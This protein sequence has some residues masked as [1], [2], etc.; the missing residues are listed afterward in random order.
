MLGNMAKSEL[1]FV[2]WLYVTVIIR[3]GTSGNSNTEEAY[4]FY[5]KSL[6]VMQ[7]TIQRETA[8]GKF[9]DYL[10]N[11]VSSITAASVSDRP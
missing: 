4:W 3:D 9:S 10:I 2:L 6:K 7:E 1:N 8:A 11:A 5:N